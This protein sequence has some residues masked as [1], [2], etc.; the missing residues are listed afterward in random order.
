MNNCDINPYIYILFISVIM[1][2]ALNK[3]IR[4]IGKY[5]ISIL[6]KIW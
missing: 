3:D 5:Y 2:L 1:N 6:K 4:L